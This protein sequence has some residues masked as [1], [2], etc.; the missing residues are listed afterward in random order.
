MNQENLMK[1]LLAP[2]ISEKATVIGEKNNQYVFHV[3][4]G[5]SKP[6]IKKAVELMFDVKVAGIRTVNIRGKAKRTGAVRGRR[7]DV[8]KAYVSLKP[9]FGI[10]LMGTQ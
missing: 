4:P 3:A 6:D 1:V 2:H 5:S 8:R 10:D 7:R 9:G